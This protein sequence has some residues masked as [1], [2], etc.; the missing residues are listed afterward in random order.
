MAAPW[1]VG[2]SGRRA[3]LSPAQDKATPGKHP[4]WDATQLPHRPWP[5][6]CYFGEP[7]PQVGGGGGGSPGPATVPGAQRG[8]GVHPNLSPW[9]RQRLS[10]GGKRRLQQPRDAD[11]GEGEGSPAAAGAAAGCS[12]HPQPGP[13]AKTPSAAPKE[14]VGTGHPTRPPASPSLPSSPAA[15]WLSPQ[16]PWAQTARRPRPRPW[17]ILWPK[18]SAWGLE[19]P[20]LTKPHSAATSCPHGPTTPAEDSPDSHQHCSAH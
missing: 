17:P 4:F 10:G 5:R 9:K 7:E 1:W 3:L 15:P 18:C 11:K 19:Q 2:S 12:Q 20:S 8:T 13:A 16:T 14:V 6:G